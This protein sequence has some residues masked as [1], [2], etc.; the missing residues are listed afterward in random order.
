MNYLQKF[1]SYTATKIYNFALKLFMAPY[2]IQIKII[3]IYFGQKY[4]IFKSNL[5]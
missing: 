1:E 2:F 5:R 4:L 3:R